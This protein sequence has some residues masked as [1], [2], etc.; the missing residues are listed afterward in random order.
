MQIKKILVPTDFS[1]TSNKAVS[2]AIMLAVKH[3][4]EL[5]ALH[6]RVLYQDDP[7]QIPQRLELLKEKED[8]IEAE[9]LDHMK[10]QIKKADIPKIKHEIIR[11]YSAPS[12]ILSYINSNK[13]DLVVIGTHGRSGLGH[14]LIGSVAE[15]VVRYA[16]CPVLTVHNRSE[17]REE[18]KH[19]LI[20]FDFSDHARFA[21]TVALEMAESDQTKVTLLYAVDRAVHPA[22]FAWG[23]KSIFDIIPDI[24][25]KA[26]KKMD[27]IIAEIPNPLKARIE[28]KIVEGL[29]HNEIVNFVQ[30]SDVDLV[31][32]ATK[33]LVGLDRLLLGS[34][35]EK[36][37]RGAHVQL[38][39]LKQ[40]VSES[41]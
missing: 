3:R 22:L 41:Q 33:G 26:K 35:T 27:E 29:A 39:T 7:S 9:L 20:P 16:N 34:T 21:L 11:G 28:K 31:V 4:A 30:D 24:V 13:F 12:A 14:F 1:E 36:V 23:M 8:K 2:Q 6:A 32:M 40:K 10:R 15:K 38:L 19:L 17:A 37:I 25:E 18:F 5:V